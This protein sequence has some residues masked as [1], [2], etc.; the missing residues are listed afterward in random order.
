MDYAAFKPDALPLIPA[1]RAVSLV[2]HA[3]R[4]IAALRYQGPHESVARRLLT[5]ALDEIGAE[6]HAS[7]DAAV[8]VA[9]RIDESLA[10][11]D[12][13]RGWYRL[14][15]TPSAAPAAQVLAHDLS[16][17]RHGLATFV[18]ILRAA[19]G[20]LP[21]GTISDAPRIPVRGVM[22]DVSRNKVPTIQSL[23]RFIDQMESLKLNHLQL[24]TEHTFAYAGH[25][26]V[27][28]NASPITPGE[29]RELDAYAAERGVEL[30]ANQNCF[31]H[32]H[33]WL[34]MPRY[35][36][37]A[38]I[39]PGVAQWTFESD[40]GRA[41]TKHG[42]HSLCPTDPRSIGLLDDLLSQLL[43][44][45]AS[46]LVNIGCDEAFDVGQ[47]RSREAVRAR[48]RAAVYFDHLR[49][50]DAIVRRMGKRPMFWADIALRH[51]DQLHLIPEGAIP[52]AWGY[53]ADAPF[54]HA[55]RV[56]E[57]RTPAPW[58]CPGT[59]CWLSMTGRTANRH[60]NLR[61]AAIEAAS[62]G[63]G[64]LTCVWGDRGHRQHWP[65]SL[66]AIAHGAHESWTGGDARTPFD[67]R[68]SSLHCLNDRTGVL[69]PWL[70]SLGE[71]DAELSRPHRNT[72]ALFVEMHRPLR[73][74]PADPIR[75][76]S[77]G[78]WAIVRDRL[79]ELR[80]SLD[81]MPPLTCSELVRRELDHTL[82]FAELAADK[83]L[84]C[85]ATPDRMPGG[86]ARIRLAAELAAL[87]EEHA[88][89]WPLRNR[90]GGL[91]E[92]AAHYQRL[93][94]DAEHPEQPIHAA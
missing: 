41:F 84:V 21:Q 31:G 32:L 2:A 79:G 35:A 69:G 81:R 53:E 88:D 18:Q 62:A 73:D 66:H 6:W 64:M 23:R 57:H 51:A 38:E 47:G 93:I 15:L 67:P 28:S 5:P 12:R 54:A 36:P 3:G 76:G 60:A 22:L 7:G 52:L 87:A 92:S 55:R 72:N 24:Y 61:A 58:F 91:D 9:A 29:A 8:L 19:S 4:P 82:W 26:E 70:E 30:S 56:L 71:A 50:V 68:A 39:P 1:P 33:R 78:E 75:F 17:L 74:L 37:L 14:D 40:D 77:T 44:C 10:A 16:G 94:D 11:A 45:F 49:A 59:G 27:W 43:P 20:I 90:P 83:A 34:S 86:P 65:V 85:R 25:E 42:P 13:P 80:A 89:L 46:P 48:G 63:S